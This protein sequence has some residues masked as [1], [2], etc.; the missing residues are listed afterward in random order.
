M[1]EDKKAHRARHA[2]RKAE[3][4]KLAQERKAE[5]PDTGGDGS[6]KKAK[7]QGN[8][9]KAFAIQSINKA[10]RRVMRTLDK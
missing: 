10:R 2:G 4:R 5:G 7:Q 1:D 3:K 6:K 8:N 9:P